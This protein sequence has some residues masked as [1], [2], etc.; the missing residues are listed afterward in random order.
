VQRRERKNTVTSWQETRKR[1]SIFLF[2]NASRDF[3][4]ILPL[5]IRGGNRYRNKETIGAGGPC[6]V[7]N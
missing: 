6:V 1:L 2:W 3:P 7:V 5:P 4:L